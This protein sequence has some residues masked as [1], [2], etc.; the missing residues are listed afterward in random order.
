MSLHDP[1]EEDRPG[2]RL[3]RPR[4][5][6]TSGLVLGFLGL[7]VGAGIY[8]PWGGVAGAFIGLMVWGGVGILVDRR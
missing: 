4:P 5:A 6:R 3:P 7:L 2:L 8:G 1:V